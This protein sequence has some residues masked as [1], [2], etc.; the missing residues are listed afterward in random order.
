MLAQDFDGDGD[1]DLIAGNLGKNN[2]YQPSPDRPVTMLAKDFDNNGAVDPVL[3]AYFKSDFEDSTFKPYPV[4]FWGDLMSQSPMFR[5]KFNYFREFASTTKSDMFTQEELEGVD[6]LMANH[7]QT[8]YFENDG[9]GKFKVGDLPW[10]TQSAPIKCMITTNA[11]G[12]ASN[13]V[14]MIGNDFGNEVFIG[15]YD[16]FN[17]GV[18]VGDEKGG[19]EFKNAEESGFRVTGDAK[20]MIQV[21]NAN[22]GSP[23]IVVTQNRGKALVFTKTE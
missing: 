20:D 13:D 10:Q 8:T 1:V 7:D 21:E 15:R 9:N 11:N 23:Y 14:L 6:E 16:A 2:L 12:T 18:L 4:N 22:G 19:F 3:F 5:K 17:G